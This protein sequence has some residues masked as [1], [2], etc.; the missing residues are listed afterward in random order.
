MDDF[1]GNASETID[2]AKGAAA[3]GAAW[4]S[5]MFARWKGI[6]NRKVRVAIAV[7]VFFAVAIVLSILF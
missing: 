2:A 3:A 7:G 4:V 1:I 5:D 6:E